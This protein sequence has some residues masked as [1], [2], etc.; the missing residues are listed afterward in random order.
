MDLLKIYS[1][2]TELERGPEISDDDEYDTE[3][4]GTTAKVQKTTESCTAEG[5]ELNVPT[6]ILRMEPG[7][8]Q[9]G[10]FKG[11]FSHKAVDPVELEF[12]SKVDEA[13]NGY[14]RSLLSRNYRTAHEFGYVTRE[15]NIL[16]IPET[17]LSV[18]Y[19]TK[20][21]SRQR[22]CLPKKCHLQFSSHKGKVN[23]VQW[24]R[25]YGQLLA[26]ASMDGSVLV[27]DPFIKKGCVQVLEGH[28]GGV[29]EVKWTSTGDHILSCSY[30]KT[31]KLWDIQTGLVLQTAEI[32]ST[33]QCRMHSRQ[34]V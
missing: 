17:I 18:E 34:P 19:G 26:S 22:Y 12:Y 10:D 30:D 4:C 6:E 20:T 23:N 7:T 29:R 16:A 25:P 21:G 11:Q 2:D 5:R 33:N 28:C 27:W 15:V 1:S 24:V 32:V 31:V 3:W 14:R 8:H 9:S 13:A